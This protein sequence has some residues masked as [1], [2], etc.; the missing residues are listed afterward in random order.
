MVSERMYITNPFVTCCNGKWLER[1]NKI[2]IVISAYG[3]S[4]L[5]LVVDNDN[6]EKPKSDNK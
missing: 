4:C 2:I 1:R 3:A 5:S 6:S